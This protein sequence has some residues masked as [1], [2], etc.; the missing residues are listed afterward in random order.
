LEIED[1]TEEFWALP[2]FVQVELA[3][4]MQPHQGQPSKPE[5]P[6]MPEAPRDRFLALQPKEQLDSPRILL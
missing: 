2:Q 6:E 1:L 4:T 3:Q 5:Q